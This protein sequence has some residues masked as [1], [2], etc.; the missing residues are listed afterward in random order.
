MNTENDILT[1]AQNIKQ[2]CAEHITNEEQCPFFRGYT[3]QGN[4]SI[5]ICELNKGMC[6]P[7]N[8]NI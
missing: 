4:V 8:W 6:S 5:V 3:K 7:C 2:Y 1:Q